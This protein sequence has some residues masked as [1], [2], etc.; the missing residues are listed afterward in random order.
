MA[1]PDRCVSIW[2]AAIEAPPIEAAPIGAAPRESIP[3]GYPNC[4][5][6]PS[7]KSRSILGRNS[8]AGEPRPEAPFPRRRHPLLDVL[9]HLLGRRPPEAR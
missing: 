6:K 5:R 1:R 4:E 2:F 9:D 7:A 3:I 8:A